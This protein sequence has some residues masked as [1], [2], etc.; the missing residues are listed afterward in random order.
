MTDP[1]W[2][3]LNGKIMPKLE[4]YYQD[5]TA[6]A[7]VYIC[8]DHAGTNHPYQECLPT[9]NKNPIVRHRPHEAARVIYWSYVGVRRCVQSAMHSAV[10]VYTTR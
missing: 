2:G 6:R 10:A 7:A 4:D 5:T 3:F 1:L 9:P 8:W